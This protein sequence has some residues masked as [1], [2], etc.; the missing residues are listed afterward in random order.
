MSSEIELKFTLAASDAARFKKLALLRG[1]K[2]QRERL[3]STYW[4][5]L[6]FAVWHA[7]FGLRVRRAG[8][9]Q[10]LSLKSAAV[11]HGGLHTRD[12]WER[13]LRPRSTIYAQIKNTIFRA[14][15]AEEVGKQ[16]A[17][18]FV[19]D[20]KR[21][22]WLLSLED[23]VAELTLDE[24]DICAGKRCEPTIEVEIELKSGSSSALFELA[25]T[26]LLEIPLRLESR[27]KAER[28]YRLAGLDLP[29]F[30]KA[31]T[32][33]LDADSSLAAAAREV[34]AE[35]L[36]HIDANSAGVLFERDAE[37]LHQLRVAV[38][39]T[40]AALNLFQDAL[41]AEFSDPLTQ[42]LRWLMQQVGPAR[43]WDV[44]IAQTLAPVATQHGNDKSINALA[45][46][47]KRKAGAARTRARRAVAS[48][49][50]TEIVLALGAWLARPPA[51]SLEIDARDSLSSCAC[52]LLQQRHRRLIKRGHKLATLSDDERHEVRIAA[53]KLRYAAEF[54][55][56][57]FPGKRTRIY[58]QA[59]EA[60]QDVLGGLN[61]IAVVTQLSDDLVAGSPEDRTAA[62]IV[63]KSLRSRKR[64]LLE[65]MAAAWEIL[66]RAKRFWV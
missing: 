55:A 41:P 40:R 45:T 66:H 17:P 36:R 27:S 5:T 59:L 50:Y 29:V 23:G 51:R 35:C 65:E 60:L 15:V 37:S 6:E 34:L 39:R 20:F 30:H 57:I 38:R 13:P 2:P 22:M 25:H 33:E 52:E 47:A 43:D 46:A 16:L 21:T 7:G 63:K 28:G 26:L 62:L 24:G 3:I 10:I 4:D 48:R 44:F 58:L 61:D 53:K 9:R 31:L 19:T 11:A 1:I 18:C 8:R 54:F 14:R 32:P 12:E 56:V 49:R 42:Q 64:I